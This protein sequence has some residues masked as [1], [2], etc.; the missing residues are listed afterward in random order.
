[1]DVVSLGLIVGLE[2]VL[3]LGFATVVLWRKHR[4]LYRQLHA[5]PQPD[6]ADAADGFASI[7]SGYLPYLEKEILANRARLELGEAEDTEDIDIAAAL[8]Q[9]LAVLS[10]KKS[11]RVL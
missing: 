11:R 1:M 4:A 7:E 5:A 2:V 3:L 8:R 9:R 6:A 10:G